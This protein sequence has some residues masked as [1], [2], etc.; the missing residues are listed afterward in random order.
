MNRWPLHRVRDAVRS[1]ERSAVEI[2][3]GALDAIEASDPSLHAFNT[4]VAERA[5]A[6]AAAIDADLDRWRDAPLA[7]V[8]VAL[9]DNLSTRGVRTTASSRVLEHYVPPYD[10]T[11]VV[12][13]EQAGAVIVGKT[14]CD[15]FA[16]GSSNENSAFGPARNPW[17]L[18]RITGGSSGGSAAAV[19]AGLAPLALGSDTGGSIRQPAA[20]CGIVGLKPT[21]GR[22]SRYG[23]LA[24]AS[25]LD[26]IGPLTLTVADAAVALS[27]L[28]GADPADS[29][30][31]D[32][33]VPDYAAALTGDVRGTRIGV[34]KR[35]LESGVDSEVAGAFRSALDVLRG[36]GAALVDIDLP[37]ARH[38]I[39]VYYLVATAE[40]S[41]NLARYD[42]V[43]YGF[44]ARPAN[45]AEP[46][47][48]KTM[49]ARTRER[50]FGPE[51]KRRIML[52]TYVL[53]AG[54]YDAYYLKAQ[55]V[56]TLILRDY[57]RAWEAVDVVAM[58]TS[59]TPAFR[60]GERA[61][62]PLQMYLADVFTVSANLAGLPA[63]SVPCGFTAG[64][65]PIGLQLTGRR[66]DEAALL[67]VA[68]AY[69]RD[70]RWWTRQPPHARR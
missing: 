17:D 23:L 63:L 40:A 7:G 64:G 51:V 3:R 53:S 56:R 42:G 52:G 30:S 21:Y 5:L 66:F 55:Q 10:A 60:I 18:D 1:G 13:L 39:A 25:S 59:P 58:P 24:F 8:P 61:D 16:M 20:L 34:P 19:A 69:E 6:R 22:V 50:G 41:S 37:H 12:R 49:Y 47:D 11:A 57:D 14:N 4:I 70:T 35:L 68:D 45:D 32:E 31:A 67:R 28:A 46:F 9:K 29:T 38:A 62:D 15:E 27:A 48:L 54:Y 44:R 2:C 33:P 43:R 26:Q 65:L 36:R